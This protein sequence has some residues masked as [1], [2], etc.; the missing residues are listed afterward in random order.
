[1]KLSL[2][3]FR[4]FDRT[5]PITIAPVTF[6]VGENST[7]K[8]TVLAALRLMWDAM[9]AGKTVN[10]NERPFEFGTFQDIRHVAPTHDRPVFGI[11]LQDSVGD[12]DTVIA[13]VMFQKVGVRPDF[14]QFS[15]RFEDVGINLTCQYA[16]EPNATHLACDFGNGEGL[17]TTVT[18]F[19][20][21]TDLA[22]LLGSLVPDSGAK[23]DELIVRLDRLRDRF[24]CIRPIALAP[25]R[26]RP[27]RTYD[28]V[29]EA[30]QADGGHIP[31]VLA[32]MSREND[33]GWECLLESL[34]EFG[35]ASG[36]FQEL[37]V[38]H[39]DKDSESGP[40][41]LEA[42][43]GK[44]RHNIMD[45]G[46]GVSQVLPVIV[47]AILAPEHSM[48]LIQQPEVHLHPRA[49][50]A[51]G[52]LLMQLAISQDKRFVIETH[53]DYMV[54]RSR[55]M[56]REQQHMTPEMLSINYF[57]RSEDQQSVQ[58]YPLTV[59]EQGHLMNTPEGYR[60]FFMHEEMR[61]LGFE[62]CA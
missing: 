7:G 41:K 60:S 5:P 54:D 34:H 42:R 37:V 20:Y 48:L 1:M 8:S 38:R 36:L 28:P 6:L 4:C 24:A 40:F 46:Y 43:I 3:N 57:E 17:E 26:T 25:V 16:Y 12:V 61:L 39:L 30:Q 18:R 14:H 35:Q 32:G 51:L 53:S 9:F 19:I 11:E 15:V 29:N 33:P 21:P 45:M 22:R 52:S 2:T 62:P 55:M 49:Q 13:K 23:M 47:E 31:M 44:S 27:M 59:D 10:F 58:V 56:V 50:A